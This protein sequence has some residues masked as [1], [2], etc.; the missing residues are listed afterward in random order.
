LERVRKQ[1][2]YERRKSEPKIRI[3]DLSN[4]NYIETNDTVKGKSHE[5]GQ[6]KGN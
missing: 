4:D 3:P 5:K 2:Y 6:R 1:Q